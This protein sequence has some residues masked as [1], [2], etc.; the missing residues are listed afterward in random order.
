MIYLGK[1]S[2]LFVVLVEIG[3]VAMVLRP[4]CKAYVYIEYY[5]CIS[6]TR[7]KKRALKP[8]NK[9]KDEVEDL[10]DRDA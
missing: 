1:L 5:I 7:K 9:G 6:L 8:T 10:E 2:W 3:L 4:F